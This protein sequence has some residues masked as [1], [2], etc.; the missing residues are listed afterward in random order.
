MQFLKRSSAN[1]CRQRD[2][3]Q[4]LLP[5]VIGLCLCA[6]FLM[7]S[8]LAWFSA[9]QSVGT[10]SIQAANY[11]VTAEVLITE[12]AQPVDK[13]DGKY[14]LEAGETY[15]V[16]FT[17]N[18]N[19]TTGYCVLKVNDTVKWV[20]K[21]LEPVGYM[22]FKLIMNESA[23]L[24]IVPYWG[25]YSSADGRVNDGDTLTYGEAATVNTSS[26]AAE[27]IDPTVPSET[28]TATETTPAPAETTLPVET[29]APE[30]TT[31]PAE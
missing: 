10:L 28:T 1:K 9:S 4:M 30:V 20:T 3:Y 18:G 27:G 2:I 15:T 12:T 5:T 19:A 22:T 21:Q 31:A 16:V 17:A 8:T 24:E 26:P 14:S 7:G 6:A 11:D 25:T 23:T 29:T 13:V